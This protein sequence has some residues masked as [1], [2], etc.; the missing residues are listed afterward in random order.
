MLEI[1]PAII[2]RYFYRHLW[3]G[4][5][6]VASLFSYFFHYGSVVSYK[7]CQG[8]RGWVLRKGFHRG[9]GSAE[10]LSGVTHQ[11]HRSAFLGA[12][13]PGCPLERASEVHTLP[14]GFSHLP[15]HTHRIWEWIPKWL[16]RDILKH[17][18]MSML[19]I[20]II[21][22]CNCW[23]LENTNVSIDYSVNSW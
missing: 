16:H 5:I 22:R 11:C 20:I 4:V 9:F 3:I 2:A 6:F 1:Y 21:Y 23:S 18:D 14:G 8:L 17:S 10:S 12:S 19:C 15:L 13:C 7:Q